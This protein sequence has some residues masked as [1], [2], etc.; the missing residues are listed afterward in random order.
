M[1]KPVLQSTTMRALDRILRTVAAKDVGVS[2]VGESGTGKEVLARRLHELSPR[3]HAAFIP[4][5]CAA[6]PETLFESELF[7]HERGAFTGANVTTTGKVEAA[8]GGTLFLD[9][10]ADMPLPMQA[11][12]L[13]FLENHK[14]MRVGG[15]VKISVDVRIIC[16][17][18]RSLED[19]VAAG[20]FR[21]DLFYRVQG[22]AID[23]PP[24]RERRSDI[25]PLVREL[26][27]QL[28]ERH[29]TKP[30]RYTREVSRALLAYAWPGNIRE[31]RNV[32]ERACLLREG[33][34]VRLRDLPPVIQRAASPA[35]TARRARTTSSEVLA[36]RLDRSLDESIARI[37]EAALELED[38]NRSRAANR[39][40]ISLRTMQRFVQRRHDDAP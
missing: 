10:V 15:S 40:G 32:V 36:V 17:T 13:R 7:G 1:P 23:I 34:P 22:I 9:E 35:T 4:I 2:L 38:G 18:L 14:F 37:L 12:L 25:M 6:I 16:A 33:K 27:T 20:R 26:T 30:P 39:L 11:K 28:T 3:K 19:E 5:N 21:P 31:L 8:A 24:L 29:R